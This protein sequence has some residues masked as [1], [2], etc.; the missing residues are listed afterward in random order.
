MVRGQIWIVDCDQSSP[1]TAGAAYDSDDLE[2]DADLNDIMDFLLSHHHP[3]LNV[4]GLDPPP[5]KSTDRSLAALYA[6]RRR[7][8]AKVPEPLYHLLQQHQQRYD[9]RMAL[10]IDTEA[11]VVWTACVTAVIHFLF[12]VFR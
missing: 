9:Y 2:T 8:L 5:S 6:F 12:E 10:Y 11:S 4:P 1:R 3:I 7:P